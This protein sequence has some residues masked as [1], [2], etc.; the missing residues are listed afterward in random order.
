MGEIQKPNTE[1]LV[2]T[3]R[4][5][6]RFTSSSY[7]NLHP[8]IRIIIPSGLAIGAITWAWTMLDQGEYGLAFFLTALFVVFGLLTLRE[9]TRASVKLRLFVGCAIVLAGLYSAGVI[10][11]KKG[12]KPLTSLW[13]QERTF[14]ESSTPTP[15]P[16]PQPTT[17]ITTQVPTP[18]PSP[19]PLSTPPAAKPSNERLRA[20]E[21]ERR[22]EEALRKLHSQD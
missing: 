4:A 17:L 22:R 15:L 13:P 20:D 21:F 9:C 5:P 18:A 6:S 10:W 1:A 12:D 19:S 7:R 8:A 14:L 2:K 16:S 3:E 11:V